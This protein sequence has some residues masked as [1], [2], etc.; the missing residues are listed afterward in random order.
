MLEMSTIQR[1]PGRGNPAF[2]LI[3]MMAVMAVT[4]ILLAAGL[5]HILGSANH[6]NK[7]DTDMLAGLIEQARITAITSRSCVVLALAEPADL[8]A[9]DPRCHLGIFKLDGMP[10]SLTD[11][12]KAVMMGRW[13][14]MEPGI[15][16]IGGK[17]DDVGNP[18]DAEKL[19]LTCDVPRHLTVNV[20]AI[21]FNPCGKLIYP[22]GTAPVTVR[23]AASVYQAGKAV[24][25]RSNPSGPTAGILMKIGRV[26]ARPYRIDK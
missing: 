26:S 10:D 18:M 21:A 17:G 12:P 2:S 15:A 13:H 6:P 20:H 19:T 16:L 11:Q 8:P 7:A 14:P 5:E 9:R 1:H 4:V 23:A 3:E 24:P 22:P 25:I